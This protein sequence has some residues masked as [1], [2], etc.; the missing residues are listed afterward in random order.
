MSNGGGYP[1]ALPRA[2]SWL[3]WNMRGL[4]N[5]CTVHEL[6]LLMRAQDPAIVF[7]AETWANEDGL[8]KLCDDLHFDEKWVVPKVTRAG[9]P[10]FLWK[11]LV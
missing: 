5:Q 4:G 1:I 11:N 10:A 8:T 6:A 3:C 9:G 7:L 2:M